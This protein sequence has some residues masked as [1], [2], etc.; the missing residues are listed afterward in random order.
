MNTIFTSDIANQDMFTDILSVELLLKERI[1]YLQQF[2]DQIVSIKIGKQ[3]YDDDDNFDQLQNA[4]KKAIKAEELLIQMSK[5]EEGCNLLKVICQAS[6]NFKII[7]IQELNFLSSDIVDLLRNQ[8]QLQSLNLQFELNNQV[9]NNCALDFKYLCDSLSDF[10]NLETLKI[11][12]QNLDTSGFFDSFKKLPQIKELQLIFED[13]K[14]I[15]KR[16]KL[17]QDN[18]VSQNQLQSLKLSFISCTL[19]EGSV[20][21]FFTAMKKA[22][23]NL[24]QFSFASS[25]KADENLFQLIQ[26]F[27][28]TQKQLNL[29]EIS[30]FLFKEKMLESLNKLLITH[31][32][33]Q[34]LTLDYYGNN[35]RNISLSSLA[36]SV[37]TLKEL[38]NLKVLFDESTYSGESVIELGEALKNLP[39]LKDL[40]LEFPGRLREDSIYDFSNLIAKCQHLNYLYIYF[41][42]YGQFNFVEFASES[43]EQT[44]FYNKKLNIKA[45]SCSNS[46]YS[47]G[48]YN[49]Y[50]AQLV[51]G[52]H[53]HKIEHLEIQQIICK[54]SEINFQLKVKNQF[55]L[56]IEKQNSLKTIIFSANS[57]YIINEQIYLLIQNNIKTLE[58]IELFHCIDYRL[59]KILINQPN[60]L[61]LK[62]E[63]LFYGS[64]NLDVYFKA[65]PQLV[66][67]SVQ[68]FFTE[69]NYNQAFSYLQSDAV[70]ENID[71]PRAIKNNFYILVNEFS[72]IKKTSLLSLNAYQKYIKQHLIYKQD[73]SHLD[74]WYDI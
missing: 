29:L 74:L 44:I 7:E 40:R 9:A 67:I 39:E 47:S 56:L 20:Q 70:L 41:S 60:L 71:H 14:I 52:N 57:K 73:L 18:I 68:D 38:R 49:Y 37:S 28:S 64:E 45:Q 12:I 2:G 30:G 24:L 36:K 46:Q 21:G 42:R 16:F 8:D 5:S 11:T 51:I 33:L 65:F 53:F 63:P 66:F 55:Q 27:V 43:T 10:K 48:Y 6:K 15:Q 62:F 58:S 72:M 50:L 4:L 25:V 1:K 26:Q 59:L 69:I 3:F 31:K 35:L 32:T 19:P 13:Q 54:Q 23:F 17:L 61:K 22:S 34:N